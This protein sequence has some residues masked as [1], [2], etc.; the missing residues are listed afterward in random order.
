MEVYTSDSCDSDTREQKTL[1]FSRMNLTNNSFEFD[2]IEISKTKKKDI[3][4]IET[5]LLN[6]NR[7]S[8]LPLNFQNYCNLKILD[9]SSNCLT[10]LPDIL[11][12]LPL[13][14]LIAKNNLLTNKTLPKS[15]SKN[16][17]LKEIN[18]SGNMLTHF[19]EQVIELKTLKYLYLG[20][21]KISNISKDIW[22]MTG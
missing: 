19:P 8:I 18:L 7:L 16:G 15:L 4:D 9:I 17:N 2:L 3:R 13:V 1:D 14:T 5:I 10:I 11:C 6:H 20:G 21:N 22:K 12:Q